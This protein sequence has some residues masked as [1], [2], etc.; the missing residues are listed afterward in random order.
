MASGSPPAI[1]KMLEILDL[2]ED[3]GVR[4]FTKAR[5]R[6]QF[7]KEYRIT[8]VCKANGTHDHFM[9]KSKLHN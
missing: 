9:N 8:A 6:R 5:Y 2:E 3:I 7:E 4:N 1:Y